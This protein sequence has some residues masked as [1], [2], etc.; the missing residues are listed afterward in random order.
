MPVAVDNRQRRARVS[1][2]VVAAAAR[3]AMAALGRP[4]ADLE[5]AL[6]DDAQIRALNATW[7]G[8]R[9]RTDVLAFPLE[10]PG[11]AAP[12]LGQLVVS[13]ET[14]RRQ[15]RRLGVAVAMEL[16]LLVTHGTLHLAGWDD[17]DPVESD[18]MHRRER[19]ILSS[20][21]TRP[22]ARLWRG[23]LAS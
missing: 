16:A 8:V 15:A 7:R 14:A 6:V 22:P 11:G 17:R 5:I 12:L 10:T 2:A 9:R 4:G 13:V 19:E 21:R 3:R 18:L 20:R 23:L 1:K